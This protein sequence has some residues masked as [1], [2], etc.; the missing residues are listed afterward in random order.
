M[1]VKQKKK[2]Q[3]KETGEN[4]QKGKNTKMTSK[5]VIFSNIGC[6]AHYV[7]IAKAIKVMACPGTPSQTINT[8]ELEIMI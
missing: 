2:K 5:N 6:F 3:R 4:V 1:G 8:L 7:V